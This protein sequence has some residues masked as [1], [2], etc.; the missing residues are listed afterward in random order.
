MDHLR[1]LYLMNTRSTAKGFKALGALKDLERF[2]IDGHGVNSETITAVLG[3]KKLKYLTL[4]IAHSDKTS[5][6][7]AE[8]KVLGALKEIEELSVFGWQIT[9]ASLATIR[10]FEKLQFI[11]LGYTNIKRASAEQLQKDLPKCRV[12]LP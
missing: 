2:Q 7:D 10:N 9:D 1:G 8:F 3:M 4:N 5:A 11:E 12:F 6:G